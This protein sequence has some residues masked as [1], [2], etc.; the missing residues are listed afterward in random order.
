MKTVAVVTELAEVHQELSM[1]VEITPAGTTASYSGN[2]LE[3]RQRAAAEFLAWAD[4]HAHEVL[5][6]QAASAQVEGHPDRL[7]QRSA[8]AQQQVCARRRLHAKQLHDSAMAQLRH[9]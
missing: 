6:Q 4:H 8:L 2:V 5:R 1:V 9:G 3:R 7:D